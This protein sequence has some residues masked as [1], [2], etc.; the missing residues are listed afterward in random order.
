MRRGSGPPSPP[1]GKS[2]N[3]IEIYPYVGWGVPHP[4]LWILWV[5]GSEGRLL[6]C[7]NM[8]ALHAY[9]CILMHMH[10]YSCKC[11]RMHVHTRICMHMHAHACMHAC[12]YVC[13]GRMCICTHL[14]AKAHACACICMHVHAHSCMYACMCM[15]MYAYCT[16][17]NAR[18]ENLPKTV[19]SMGLGRGNPSPGGGGHE[20]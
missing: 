6:K 15:H 2:G 16:C 1:G 10:A 20:P 7:N 8:H 19:E 13:R 4:P 3:R 11:M 5:C 12:T 17:M 18:T 9:A 14:H